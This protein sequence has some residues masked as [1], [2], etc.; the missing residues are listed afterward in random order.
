MAANA[1]D[2]VLP[3]PLYA[4]V[5]A[6][7]AEQE[8]YEIRNRRPAHLTIAQKK[9]LV[10]LRPPVPAGPPPV[11][12]AV[13]LSSIL[14]VLNGTISAEASTGIEKSIP[15]RKIASHPQ[16][17][18]P[19]VNIVDNTQMAQ[20]PIKS[21]TTV[22][23]TNEVLEQVK[24]YSNPNQRNNNSQSQ[25]TSVSQLSD[26]QPTDWAFQALQS[27]VERYGVIAGYPDGTFRGN[28]A[29]TRYEF[30]A[31][32]NA[33]LDR[34]NELI[35]AGTADLITRDNLATLQKLQQE[36][37]A[38]LTTLRGRIDSLEAYTA[39]LFQCVLPATRCEGDT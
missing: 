12:S 36:F 3:N 30:A 25:V 24:Q 14:L 23:E 7:L 34:I 28:R 27:L 11:G 21:T 8:A 1:A 32:L 38:E 17:A 16:D 19:Q 4:E 33:A 15:S 37:A 31:G 10:T 29:L 39:E 2:Q 13:V 35:A 18:S 9:A 22:E 20:T 5:R 6:F 26:V